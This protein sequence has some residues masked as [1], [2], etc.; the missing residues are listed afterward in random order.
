MATETVTTLPEAIDR[1]WVM[2]SG[3]LRNPGKLVLDFRQTTRIDSTALC[4]IRLLNKSGRLTLRNIAPDILATLQSSP[5]PAHPAPGKKGG[6]TLLVNIGDRLLDSANMMTA[7][8]SILAEMLYWGTIGLFKRQ[9]FRKGSLGDQMFQLGYKALGIVGLLSF[10]I[11]LVLA[12]QTAIQLKTFGAGIFLGPLVGITMVRE[13]GPLLTAVILAG[14]TGSAT[15]AEIGTM[16]VGEELDA[17][18][19]MGINP[20]QFIVV[21]KFWAITFTMPLLSILATVA[22]IL[23]GFCVSL[24][25]LDLSSNLYWGELGKALFF[26][27]VMAGFIKSVVFSWLIIWI[28]AFYG[29]NVRGGAESVGKETTASVVT[30]IFVIIIADALFSFVL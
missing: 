16:G 7:S 20:I 23:G 19:T 5:L 1:D 21:P 22:G 8:L 12:L 10:L 29:F 17:L 28:G 6:K 30:C 11:G 25:Y 27:D 4:A 18:R 13:M 24:Y 2:S 26:K 14:R 15:A 9:D 3:L